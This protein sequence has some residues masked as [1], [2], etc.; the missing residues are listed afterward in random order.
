MADNTK[1]QRIPLFKISVNQKFDRDLYYDDFLIHPRDTPITE[2]DMEIFRTWKIETPE[3]RDSTITGPEGISALAGSALSD[4]L[5]IMQRDIADMREAEALHQQISNFVSTCY[6]TIRRQQRFTVGEPLNSLRQMIESIRRM[7]F[8]IL[9]FQEFQTKGS[10]IEIHSVNSFILTVALANAAKMPQHRLM[11][12]ALSALLHEVG[13][14]KFTNMIDRNKRLTPQE[15]QL[16]KSHVHEGLNMLKQYNFPSEVAEGILQHHER[17]DGSG[18]PYGVANNE[19]LDF[20]RYIGLV[21]SYVA[22][23]TD[24]QFRESRMAHSALLTLMKGANIHYDAE[25]VKLLVRLLS[26][27]PVGSYV[28]LNNG[29]IGRVLRNNERDP[30]LPLIQVVLDSN[31][32]LIKESTVI[33]TNDKIRVAQPLSYKGIAPIIAKLQSQQSQK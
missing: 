31:R 27:Y 25:L 3:L 28:S 19:I 22:M 15:F 32:K 33:Q 17:L 18:Y 14:I 16:Q 13:L 11:N 8:S 7:D 2:E 10:Y 5:D 30:R 26:L 24:Q 1:I 21:C 12:L 29:A 9:R 4:S 23:T 20:G 6:Q